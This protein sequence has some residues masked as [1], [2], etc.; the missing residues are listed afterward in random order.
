[1]IPVLLSLTLFTY[2]TSPS[3]PPLVTLLVFSLSFVI[4]TRI[5]AFKVVPP[6]IKL[7]SHDNASKPKSSRAPL[8]ESD[9][10]PESNLTNEERNASS[11]SCII[12]W[13]DNHAI[14]N[15]YANIAGYTGNLDYNPLDDRSDIYNTSSSN[16]YIKHVSYLMNRE[17][18]WLLPKAE[19]VNFIFDNIEKDTFH[20][21]ELINQILNYP[22]YQWC[23]H[24]EHGDIRKVK[25]SVPINLS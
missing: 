9:T 12:K 21:Q 14:A 24:P 22:P 8:L 18:V 6:I 17:N 16:T 20:C 3:F 5:A 2:V 19:M 1:M 7:V 11:N 4:T 25:F 10:N 15:I 23:P 13:G